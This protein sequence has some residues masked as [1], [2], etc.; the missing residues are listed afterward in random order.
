MNTDLFKEKYRIPAN[1]LKEWDYGSDG[2]YFVTICEWAMRE[3]FGDIKNGKMILTPIG[4]IADKC[5]RE[6]PQH[7]PFVELDEFVVMPNHVHGIIRIVGSRGDR[8]VGAA[9]NDVVA[10][11][12]VSVETQ[13][14][15]SLRR[16]VFGPQSRNLASVVRGFKIG[17]TK[18]ARNNQM[19]FRWQSRYYDHVAR[20]Q[21]DLDRIRHYIRNNPERWQRDRNNIKNEFNYYD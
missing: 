3:Y 5:W 2:F 4:E 10:D 20:D 21:N 1:R 18:Y 9:G 8:N 11:R 12:N 14:L 16:N 6:I 13:N 7:F 15:A 19:D 17:V